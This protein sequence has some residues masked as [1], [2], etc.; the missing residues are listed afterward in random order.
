MKR[1]I[2]VVAVVVA[3]GSLLLLGY[4]WLAGSVGVQH[5]LDVVDTSLL[6]SISLVGQFMIHYYAPF[7]LV[8]IVLIARAAF[9][10]RESPP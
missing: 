10:D 3:T 6:R 8:G 4:D 9:R 7:L 1:R 5:A 2:L